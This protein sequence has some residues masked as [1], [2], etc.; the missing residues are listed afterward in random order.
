M[1][2][3]IIYKGYI[4]IDNGAEYIVEY[5]HNGIELYLGFRVLEY[6]KE[7]IDNL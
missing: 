7:F 6:A 4:I 5:N 2:K 1:T 3:N